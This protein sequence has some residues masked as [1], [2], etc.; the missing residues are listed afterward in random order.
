MGS[1]AEADS[2][3]R[4]PAV[5][6]GALAAESGDFLLDPRELCA[7]RVGGEA[8]ETS[9]L[10]RQ[11]VERLLEVGDLDLLGEDS[12][13]VAELDDRGL[14]ARDR[15]AHAKR[16]GPF[17]RL[18]R[19]VLHVDDVAAEPPGGAKCTLGGGGE[20]VCAIDEHG[21]RR[22]DVL[23]PGLA[24]AWGG[25][26]QVRSALLGRQKW[27]RVGRAVLDLGCRRG[28][29]DGTARGR[30]RLGH[31]RRLD[32]DG[33]GRDDRCRRDGR[34]ADKDDAAQRDRPPG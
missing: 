25:G 3:E 16:R 32:P 23:S 1:E 17:G 15:D 21:E 30:R 12:P 8:L 4:G 2:G 18:R 33:E 27:D 20:V 34:S 7:L 31:G 13:E 11:F 22:S 5:D 9:D 28:R 10:P 29:R 6:L 24:G 14:D 19:S 26:P